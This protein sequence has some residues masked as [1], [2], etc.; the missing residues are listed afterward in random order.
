MLFHL[1]T[2]WRPNTVGYLAR[3]DRISS[4]TSGSIADR[5][6]GLAWDSLRV[7]DVIDNQGRS[8]RKHQLIASFTS[9]TDVPDYRRGAYWS[10]RSGIAGYHRP[11]ALACP[12][13]QNK[14]LTNI[15]TRP[16]KR[17][18]KEQE[19]LIN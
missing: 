3:N 10:I 4:V 7:L 19:R 14:R 2:L 16:T 9:D 8:L 18:S 5:M 1:G 17:G 6:P 11:D 13:K 15:A 12:I